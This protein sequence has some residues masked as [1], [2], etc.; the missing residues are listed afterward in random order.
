MFIHSY[1][2][3]GIIISKDIVSIFPTTKV[4]I[5]LKKGVAG[6]LYSETESDRTFVK[7]RQQIT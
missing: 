3:S 2:V 4:H 1:Y 7:E 5:S 6:R